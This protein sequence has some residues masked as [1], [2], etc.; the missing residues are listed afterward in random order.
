MRRRLEFLAGVALIV[1]LA[2]AGTGLWRGTAHSEDTGDVTEAL[3]DI[4]KELETLED[5]EDSLGDIEKR[6]DQMERQLDK[7]E[8]VGL[9]TWDFVYKIRIPGGQ[10]PDETKD[11]QDDIGKGEYRHK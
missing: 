1:V 4:M 5:I 3:E 6:L 11:M 7:M 9:K 8:R 10:S 2:V